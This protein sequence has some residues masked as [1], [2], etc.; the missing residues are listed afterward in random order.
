MSELTIPENCISALEQ[1]ILDNLKKS[2]EKRGGSGR[3][4]WK[5][6]LEGEWPEWYQGM[7]DDFL[8][9]RAWKNLVNEGKLVIQA[10]SWIGWFY[11]CPPDLVDIT[12]V[13]PDGV[14]WITKI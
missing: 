10:H 4:I 13:L 5:L 3:R 1:A 14:N 9:E 6:V 2:I 8:F 12:E 11:L 7:G